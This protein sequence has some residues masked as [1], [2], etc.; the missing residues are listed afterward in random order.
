MATLLKRLVDGLTGCPAPVLVLTLLAA[1]CGEAPKMP[2]GKP[3]RGQVTHKGKP[4]TGVTLTLQDGDRGVG[5]SCVVDDQGRFDSGS[6]LPTGRYKVAF[7]PVLV[8]FEPESESG[9]A[10]A[11]APAPPGPAAPPKLPASLPRKYHQIGT[12]DLVVEIAG[13]GSDVEVKIPG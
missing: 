6:P 11:A 2:A 9:P 13:D 12:S 4:L 10:P 1:G 3:V 7:G 5:A 8:P